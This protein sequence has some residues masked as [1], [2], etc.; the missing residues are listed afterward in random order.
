MLKRANKVTFRVT[1][2][3]FFELHRKARVTGFSLEAYLRH[4]CFVKDKI[5]V[6]NSDTVH[7][8][9]TELNK[10]GS[11]INQIARIANSQKSISQKMVDHVIALLDLLIS[12]VDEEIGGIKR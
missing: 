1:E 11:N 6:L 3:E 5:V 2:N 12:K 10:V 7:S 4:C 8:V 9:Y